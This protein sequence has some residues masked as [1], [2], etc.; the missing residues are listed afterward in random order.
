MQRNEIFCCH[1]NR[2]FKLTVRFC[3]FY[4]KLAAA[5][6]QEN[7]KR[8]KTFIEVNLPMIYYPK[9]NNDNPCSQ[10]QNKSGEDQFIV[11]SGGLHIEMAAFKTIDNLLDNSGWTGALV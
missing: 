2:L 11:M 5:C 8:N 6:Q 3:C 7:E 4:L 10:L 9:N 1:G